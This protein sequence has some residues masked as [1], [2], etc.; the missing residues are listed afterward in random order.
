[1]RKT[2]IH[3]SEN[4]TVVCNTVGGKKNAFHPYCSTLVFNGRINFFRL[5]EKT[6]ELWKNE[7]QIV[8][9]V[10]EFHIPRKFVLLVADALK[11]VSHGE[12]GSL[13]SFIA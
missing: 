5:V 10:I 11:I 8:L 7:K 12:N 6:K 1:M 9:T 13:I 4:D 3:R 2:A